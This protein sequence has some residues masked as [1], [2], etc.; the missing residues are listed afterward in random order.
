MFDFLTASQNM[1]FTVAI[2]VMFGIAILEGVLTV[3]GLGLSS[4]IETFIPELEIET[5]LT[6]IEDIQSPSPLSKL[7]SWFRVGQVP[8]LMLVVVFL[9][10]FGLIGIS[11]QSFSTSILGIFIPL[12]ISVPLA[13]FLSLPVVRVFGGILH[14][15]MPKDETEA[16]TAE[17]L[18]GRIATI[19]LGK[20]SYNNPAEARVQDKHGTNHYVRVVPE[21]EN[22]EY[23]KGDEVLL[24]QRNGSIFKVILNTNSSLVDE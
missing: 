22:E 6:G 9:T 15:V 8:V 18:I 3:L 19:T 7:F 24:L 2:M 20:A 1:P 13:F 11:I 4:I 16:V 14:Q 5:S 21:H 12:I 23:F 17:S 10:A